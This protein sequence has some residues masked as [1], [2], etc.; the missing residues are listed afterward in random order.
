MTIEDIM[1]EVAKEN[2]MNKLVTGH[3][4]ALFKEVALRVAKQS[5]IEGSHWKEK[6]NKGIDGP[7]DFYNIPDLEKYIQTL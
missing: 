5:F 3:S 4:I 6:W 2:G 1:I 7:Y